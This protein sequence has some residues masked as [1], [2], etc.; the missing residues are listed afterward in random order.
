MSY[1]IGID[2]GGTYTD[3]VIYDFASGSVLAKGKSPTTRE[4]LSIGIGKALDMLPE[5]LLRQAEVIALS[6]TLAT[7]AC[8]EN[9]GGR[10]KLVMMGTS[11]KT[12]EWVNADVK[13]GLNYNDILCLNGEYDWDALVSEHDAFFHSAEALGVVELNSEKNNA[14]N[15]T[16]ARNVLKEKYGVP[17][18][19]ASELVGE[20]NIMERGATALLNAKLLPVAD[21]FM[22]AV[23]RALKERNLDALTMVVRSDG[24]LMVDETALSRPVDTILSGPAASIMGSRA[25]TSCGDCMIVDMGGT[26]T[27]ISLMHDGEAQKTRGIRIGGWRTQ[28]KGV[29]IDTFALGGD[30]RLYVRDGQLTLDNRR[31]E[32]LCSLAMR[33]P[34]IRTELEN[35]LP[36]AHASTRPLHEFF[37]LISMPSQPELYTES[38]REL[39]ALLADG[40]KML[41]SEEMLPYIPDCERPEREGLIMRCGLTPTDIMHIRGD[42]CKFDRETSLIAARCVLRSLPYYEDEEFR[43]LDP[44]CNEVY[45]LVKQ[46]LFENIA[47]IFIETTY[48]SIFKNGLDDTLRAVI[49]QKW[50]TRNVPQDGFFDIHLD[51]KTTLVGIGAP[52][53]IFLPDVAKALGAECII[54]EN[55]EV[56]NAVG[57]V[58]ADISAEGKAEIRACLLPDGEAGF[59]VYSA[60]KNLAFTEYDKALSAAQD[61][62]RTLAEKRA[63]NRGAMGEVTITMRTEENTARAKDGAKIDLGT[64]VTAR[65]TGRIDR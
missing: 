5:N 41:G 1:G 52:T 30:T 16:N 56:A 63:R 45:D 49:T 3:A 31:V 9:K 37:Y 42:Y 43:D 22:R 4:D 24:S 53:R 27:D 64:V 11:R 61:A 50:K 20:R 25:L 48:P 59:T 21:R 36:K 40:P 65:A 28:V 10:A 12:L 6:T 60:D 62:A 34:H 18:V 29:F 51:A 19:M 54:P 17:L 58:V 46:R 7:N 23:R 8:V 35:L 39:L 57:A 26:T 14:Q 44:L 2:T 15:E 33:Y 32:P 55:C 38:E 13:Y 47:R